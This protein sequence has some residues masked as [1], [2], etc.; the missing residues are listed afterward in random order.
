MYSSIYIYVYIHVYCLQQSSMLC[1]ESHLY[2]NQCMQ[3]SWL[4][5]PNRF[6]DDLDDEINMLFVNNY[7]YD[8]KV[9]HRRRLHSPANHLL[10]I[11]QKQCLPIINQVCILFFQYVWIHSFK[12]KLAQTPFLL[13]INYVKLCQI[14]KW[15]IKQSSSGIFLNNQ[16]NKCFFC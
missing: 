4:Q 2:S 3:I 9:T 6:V 1:I 8:I 15:I 16:K 14:I 10:K 12:F 11:H 7:K 13:L 5:K